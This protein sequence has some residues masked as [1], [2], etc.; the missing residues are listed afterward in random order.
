M[1]MNFFFLF[2]FHCLKFMLFFHLRF[3]PRKELFGFIV[4]LYFIWYFR[5]NVQGMNC[6]EKKKIMYQANGGGFGSLGNF[7]FL[8]C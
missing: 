5:S 3:G 7:G 4:K 1:A 6:F 8:F 2:A